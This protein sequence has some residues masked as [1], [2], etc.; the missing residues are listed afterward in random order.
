MSDFDMDVTTSGP[1]FKTAKPDLFQ[2]ERTQLDEWLLQVD[3]F[4]KFGAKNIDDKD[5]VSFISTYLR[6]QAARWIKPYLTQYL[7]ESNQDGDD[8]DQLMEDYDEFKKRIRQVFGTSNEAAVAARMIQGLSQTKS[9]ADYTAKFQQYAVQTDWDD[10]ALMVMYKQGLKGNVKAELM[11]SGTTLDTLDQLQKESIR[12]DSDLYELSIELRQGRTPR[13]NFG[14]VS[15]YPGNFRQIA[16]GE[17]FNSN[18]RMERQKRYTKT[19]ERWPQKMELDTMERKSHDRDNKKKNKFTRNKPGITCYA[20][21]KTGHISRNCQSKN[22]VVR[23]LN[24]LVRQDAT[25]GSDGQD[26]DNEWEVV[27]SPDG[28]LMT[29][30]PDDS[31][32]SGGYATS[33]DRPSPKRSTVKGEQDNEVW[34]YLTGKSRAPTPHPQ[35]NKG[36][37]GLMERRVNEKY[38]DH[39]EKY[40][41]KCTSTRARR[42]NKATQTTADE[43]TQR[44]RENCEVFSRYLDIIGKPPHWMDVS[45]ATN[46]TY[47]KNEDLDPYYLT[48]DEEDNFNGDFQEYITMIRNKRDSKP[49]HTTPEPII[50][51]YDLDY[52]NGKHGSLHWTFC[53]HDS[54]TTHYD[55]KNDA[56]WFPATKASCRWQWYD[57][58]VDICAEHLFDKRA[59]HY[60]HG[61]TPE[62]ILIM[63]MLVNG[64]CTQIQWQTCLHELCTRHKQEKM[65][66]G[67]L[68]INSFLGRRLPLELSPRY[69]QP[70]FRQN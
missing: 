11:R 47:W 43:E 36:C 67:L 66:N 3:L 17:S 38:N 27:S 64:Q 35:H 34:Q 68:Q 50:R 13:Y 21:G 61:R 44:L 2:G 4:F 39:I 56:G 1:N 23:Q 18:P 46:I 20:C 62:D 29:D 24:M 41:D 59:S 10:K 16:V 14:N 22:K 53:S 63:N 48:T 65:G 37:G 26:A 51:R 12:I 32:E 49:S 31:D 15:Q 70:Q 28:R 60:F 5:K 9:A 8:V 40:F 54:C 6:G 55:A 33:E 58:P 57:C 7:D 45:Y 19:V 69:A 52:R 30:Y 42:N 25:I